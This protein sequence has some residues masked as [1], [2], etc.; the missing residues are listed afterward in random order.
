MQPRPGHR[1]T[2]EAAA[3][4][5]KRWARW[6]PRL[7]ISVHKLSLSWQQAVRASVNCVPRECVPLPKGWLLE[8]L[9]SE[10]LPSRDTLGSQKN[11]KA[12]VDFADELTRATA[13]P[14]KTGC[15]SGQL[16]SHKLP[17]L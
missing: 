6:E 5:S 4:C 2:S 8:P 12:G 1:T 13:V 3:A 14:Y 17:L 9:K 7:P 15:M 11:A 16:L 10:F